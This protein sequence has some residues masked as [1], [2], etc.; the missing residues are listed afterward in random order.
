MHQ[1]FGIEDFAFAAWI[2]LALL[3]TFVAYIFADHPKVG[4]HVMFWSLNF[5]LAALIFFAVK[6]GGLTSP[7]LAAQVLFTTFFALLFP[8]V[9]AIVPP[10]LVLPIVTMLTAIYVPSV[11]FFVLIMLLCWHAV[12]N[13]LA[14]YTAVYLTAHEEE[15]SLAILALEEELSHLAIAEE[16][17]R[18]ARELHDGVGGILSSL[19]IQTEFLLTL[20]KGQTQVEEE[21][22]E[23]KSSAEE[24]ID[25]VRRALCMM[26]D[27][28]DLVPQLHN[29]CTTFTARSK[30]PVAL[31]ISGDPPGLTEDQ[32]LNIFRILQESLNN[33][34]QHAQATSAN[35]DV[36]FSDVGLAMTIRDNGQ[37]FDPEKTPKLH[38]GLVNMQ[39][40]AH[41]MGGKVTIHSS[42]GGGT[43]VHLAL[44]GNV[45]I[46]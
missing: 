15:Q 8:G 4:R 7:I 28:F 13:G 34:M 24:A 39:E 36:F 46:S 35:V 32:Q 1:A 18:L 6:T 27:E 25:D 23:L 19:I 30:L 20:C 45:E 11:G 44:A 41:K 22:L 33:V 43:E 26:R 12:I 42:P 40:R 17:N 10:M 16:R 5:D 37:G 29:A 14:V 9:I 3:Y 38:Y 31:E 21:L 2:G